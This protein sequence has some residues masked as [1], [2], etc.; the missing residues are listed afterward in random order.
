MIEYSQLEFMYNWQHKR[1][2]ITF[3]DTWR[4]KN[5][6]LSSD[7]FSLRNALDLHSETP[8]LTFSQKLPL[9]RFPVLWN[10][11]EVD[12]RQMW[13]PPLFKKELKTLFLGKLQ[14]Y[15]QCE[16]PFCPDCFSST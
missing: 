4:R 15:A 16:N 1:L 7:Q 8:R 2:P 12:T 14:N 11:L 9:Y 13:P 5:D 10:K 6:T 3:T